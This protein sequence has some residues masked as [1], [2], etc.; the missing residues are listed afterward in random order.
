LEQLIKTILLGIIQG[1]TEWLP[2]SSTGHLK[3]TEKFLKFLNPENSLIFEFTLH[4]GTL[5][6][7]L[8]FFK[9]DIKNLVS[10]FVH[11]SFK[12]EHGRLVPKIVAGTIP[13]VAIALALKNFAEQT[14]QDILPL[15]VAFILYGIILYSAKAGVEKTDEIS[16]SDAI[17]IGAA[18]GLSII[19]GISRS[20]ITIATALLLGIRRK[21]A[22]HFSFLLSIP[23]IIG[24]LGL[25]FYNVTSVM[26]L[27]GLGW[28]E[29]IA[30][31]VAA[32]VVG[33]FALKLLWRI[34]TKGKFHLFAFYCW[35]L[36][37]ALIAVSNSVF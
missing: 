14:F 22:F 24:A 28:A 37:L 34:L 27:A 3:L 2:I 32:M 11:L 35:M 30:G 23:A 19:P 25:E 18:E 8:L 5:I 15:A 29:V 9:E 36:G 31:V 20:G 17:I 4:I 7:V 6:V 33:Y 12:T 16:Y 1:L 26:M 13:A 21:K 10:A